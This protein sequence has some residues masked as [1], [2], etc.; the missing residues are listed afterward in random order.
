MEST[1]VLLGLRLPQA[2]Q[3]TLPDL[4]Y[5]TSCKEFKEVGC[6]RKQFF[7][8][9]LLPPKASHSSLPVSHSTFP[10]H[11]GAIVYSNDFVLARGSSLRWRRRGPWSVT[12][13]PNSWLW[14]YTHFWNIVITTGR[15]GFCVLKVLFGGGRGEE[16]EGVSFFFFFSLASSVESSHSSK[17]HPLKPRKMIAPHGRKCIS[18][19][20]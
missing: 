19:K 6:W 20:W 17:S 13:T 3:K 16:G 9:W 4:A 7:N 12:T 2:K 1:Q 18:Q 5:L 8:P 10:T 11:S 15:W 14:I